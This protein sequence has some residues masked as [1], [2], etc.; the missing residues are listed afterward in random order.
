MIARFDAALTASVIC[1][2]GSISF[3]LAGVKMQSIPRIVLSTALLLI[4]QSA[5]GNTHTHSDPA[6]TVSWY[7]HECCHDGDCRPV[8]QVQRAP[9]GLWMTTVDGATV[10]VGPSDRRLPSGD[11]RWHVCINA[12]IELQTDKI[13]C[14]F[15][16]SNS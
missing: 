6:G 3:I 14:V 16:P 4:L 13:I 9:H 15:E 5:D 11:A 1:F 10:L 7:P 2:V 12:D 8:T